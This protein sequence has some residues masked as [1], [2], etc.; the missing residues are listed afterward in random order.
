M[1]DNSQGHSAYSK[2][3]L[4]SSRMNLHPGGKQAR[5]KDGWFTQNGQKAVQPMIFLANH[6]E[7]P[8][9]PKG[10]K[11][12]LQERGLWTDKLKLKCRD[13][14][15]AGLIH[16]YARQL[17]GMQPDFQEQCSLVQE[18]IEAAGH[19]CILLP[20]FHCE[21]NFIEYF[22]GAMKRFL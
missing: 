12:V 18:V 13:K 21:L 22:W 6:P 2:D 17:L 11:Q 1:I 14:C 4:V 5:M 9:Q 20:K 3:T 8:G 19:L 16:C 15:Q 7:S 10:I